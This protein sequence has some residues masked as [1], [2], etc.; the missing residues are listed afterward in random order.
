MN[1]AVVFALR[2][3]QSGM[4]TAEKSKTSTYGFATHG[5]QLP[6]ILTLFLCALA[7]AGAIEMTQDLNSPFRGIIR[8]SSEPMKDAL[9]Q[10]SLK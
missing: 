2:S 4:L 1:P 3:I 7:V 8:I 6:A 5:T 10:I 9:N